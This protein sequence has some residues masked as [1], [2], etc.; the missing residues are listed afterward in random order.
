MNGPVP[1]GFSAK[2]FALSSG[3]APG[4]A[5]NSACDMMLVLNVARA[6]RMVGSGVFSF[7]TMLSGPAMSTASMEAIISFQ[8]PAFGSRARSSDHFTSEIFNGEPSA[9]FTPDRTVRVRVLPPSLKA[10]LLARP[11][12]TPRPS[13]VGSSSVS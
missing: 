8:A 13:A 2:A 4:A 1:I 5:S 10:H 11:S 7:S 3:V 12:C 9:N 6:A